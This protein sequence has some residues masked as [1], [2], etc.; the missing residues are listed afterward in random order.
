MGYEVITAAASKE[1]KRK[2]S[3]SSEEHPGSE[4]RL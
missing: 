1:G 4:V 3:G 2:S